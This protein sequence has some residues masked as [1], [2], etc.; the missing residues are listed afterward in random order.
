MHKH[1]ALRELLTYRVWGPDH[2]LLLRRLGLSQTNSARELKAH[3]ASSPTR[4][5]TVLVWQL[6]GAV[7]LLEA[8]PCAHT[9]ERMVNFD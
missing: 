5:M 6:V 3:T 1:N 8:G 2:P 4:I 9:M 7:V